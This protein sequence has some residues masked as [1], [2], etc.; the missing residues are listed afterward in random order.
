MILDTLENLS[1]YFGISDN[2][3]KALQWL[4]STPLMSV[5]LGKHIICGEDVFCNAIEATPKQAS[6]PTAEAHRDYLD[7]HVALEAGEQIAISNVKNVTPWS[8]YDAE[9]DA[10]TAPLP[11]PELFITMPPGTF[12]IFFPQ[13]AHC[14]LLTSRPSQQIRKLVVKVRCEI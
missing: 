8:D 14:P 9:N 2:L 12:A 7:I 4:Q 13:D 5:E 11:Q 1:S 3:D 10:Q 6:I